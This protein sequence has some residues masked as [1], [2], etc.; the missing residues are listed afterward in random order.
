MLE[1][2]VCHRLTPGLLLLTHPPTPPGTRLAINVYVYVCLRKKRIFFSSAQHFRS[3][4]AVSKQQRCFAVTRPSL[5][6]SQRVEMAQKNRSCCIISRDGSDIVLPPDRYSYSCCTLPLCPCTQ[7]RFFCKYSVQVLYRATDWNIFYGMVPDTWM[8]VY[9]ATAG[10]RYTS[11]GSSIAIAVRT[12]HGLVLYK[13]GIRLV[14]S[15]AGGKN[16]RSPATRSRVRT[17]RAETSTDVCPRSGWLPVSKHLIVF[18]AEKC[19]HE[20]ESCFLLRMTCIVSSV[21]Q[22]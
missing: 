19:S 12:K 18:F 2:E 7:T 3:Q 8:A 10:A 9:K 22:Q 11:T 21:A 4:G 1:N 15:R 14:H 20:E 16:L 6:P 5:L 17:N 13:Q